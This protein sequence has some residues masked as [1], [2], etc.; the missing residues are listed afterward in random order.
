MKVAEGECKWSAK[1]LLET[2][3]ELLSRSQD[4]IRPTITDNQ[5][6]S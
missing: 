3:P 2:T 6:S 4:T 5:P 1:K